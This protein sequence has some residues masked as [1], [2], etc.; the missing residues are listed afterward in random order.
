MYKLWQVLDPRQVLIAITVFL[1]PLGL[2]IHFLLL[3]TEDLN[4]H[5]DGRPIPLKAASA[6]DR[7]QQGLPY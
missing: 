7:A 3:A 2:L 5:E 6:Y 4:W 1:I